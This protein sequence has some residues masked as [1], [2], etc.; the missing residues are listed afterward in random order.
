MRLTE[1]RSYEHYKGGTFTLLGLAEDSNDRTRQ[2]AVY[3]SH[4]RKKLLVRPA[5]EFF[6]KVEVEGSMVMRYRLLEYDQG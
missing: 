6:G 5:A 4:R 1:L 3:V 2:M